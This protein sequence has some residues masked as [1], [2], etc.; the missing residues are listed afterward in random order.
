MKFMQ[1]TEYFLFYVDE[2]LDT[3]TPRKCIEGN[4]FTEMKNKR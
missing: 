4:V 1:L 3:C 2:I